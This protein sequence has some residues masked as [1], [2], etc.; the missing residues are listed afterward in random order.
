MADAVSDRLRTTSRFD[1]PTSRADVEFERT[2]RGG[3]GLL[4]R[5]GAVVRGGRGI[6]V[7]GDG[8][9]LSFALAGGS[10]P[11]TARCDSSSSLPFKS[12]SSCG[13]KSVG[14]VVDK[15]GICM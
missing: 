1:G 6:G 7:E 5:S 8:G 4:I 10:I 11:G 3:V 2:G 12:G 14:V 9:T 13:T 15:G